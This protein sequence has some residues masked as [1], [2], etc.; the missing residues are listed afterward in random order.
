MFNSCVVLDL[1]ETLFHSETSRFPDNK[2]KKECNQNFKYMDVYYYVFYRPHLK[3]FIESVFKN[4]DHVAIWT[5][6]EKR[7]ATKVVDKIFTPEQKDKLL[8]FY[9]RKNCVIDHRGSYTKPL[10][11]VFTNFDFL[12]FQKTVIIDNI[13][14][15]RENPNMNIRIKDFYTDK[16]DKELLKM[17]PSKKIDSV[18]RL[19]N[20]KN[21]H[22]VKK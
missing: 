19:R 3:E 13:D 18:R 22:S 11:K 2:L 7:Y 20:Y 15:S 16:K 17:Q 5:A 6:A 4:F 1:D 21:K 8:F 9:S 12:N 14:V 10:H